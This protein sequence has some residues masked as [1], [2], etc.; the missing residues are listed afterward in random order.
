[1]YLKLKLDSS[2]IL[3]G[4]VYSVYIMYNGLKKRGD[5]KLSWIIALIITS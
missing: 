4:R 1:M 3:C 2:N 5:K